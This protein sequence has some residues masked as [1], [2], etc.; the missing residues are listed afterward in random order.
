MR[1]PQEANPRRKVIILGKEVRGDQSSYFV[2]SA[3]PG[4][5]RDYTLHPCYYEDKRD[6]IY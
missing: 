6:F 1:L 4:T 3:S 5:L 2:V